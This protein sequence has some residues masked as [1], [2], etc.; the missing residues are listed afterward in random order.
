[1]VL[2]SLIFVD[3]VR[4]R[5]VKT[6]TKIIVDVSIGS[7]RSTTQL[8]RSINYDDKSNRVVLNDIILNGIYTLHL[9]MTQQ[10]I[11]P[12]FAMPPIAILFMFLLPTLHNP[13]CSAA[14]S[15]ISA[16]EVLTGA[17]K[18]VS[19]NGKFALGFYQ[20]GS[21][22]SSQQTPRHWYLGIW[23]DKI[24]KLTPIWVG[25]RENPIIDLDNSEL[26][27][28]DDGN[29]VILNRATK[30][31]IWSTHANITANNITVTILDKKIS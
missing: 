8:D 26:K 29:L 7:T 20:P 22:Y 13:A 14:R 10:G 17:G 27:I 21:E 30:S 5:Y 15:T 4:S 23:F 11:Q 19:H 31:T 2:R 1:M 16:G 18:L 9:L 25:N 28:S 24:P 3:Y 6:N 12:S